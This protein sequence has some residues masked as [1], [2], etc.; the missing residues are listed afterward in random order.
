MRLAGKAAL[1]TGA[2]G[3]IGGAIVAL[4]R[5]EGAR[6]TGL[7]LAG[8]D[9]DC[10]VADRSAVDAA[11]AGLGPIDIVVH[12]AALLGGT[13]GFLDVA[14]ADWRRYLA[15][16]LEGAFHVCQAAARVMAEGGHGGAIVTIGSVNS[17]AAEPGAAAYVASKAG[18][19]GLTRAMAVDLA[20]FGI[21]ANMVAPGPIAVPRN[22]DLFASE[23]MQGTFRRLVPQRRAGTAAD[24][25]HAALFLAEDGAAYV[26]GTVLAVDGGT[27]AQILRPD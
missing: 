15:V 25:A 24:V 7:D 9:V 17:L 11:V 3:G 5:A 18:L 19:L 20:E 8:A 6:V 2:A 27:L 14:T 10:D 26:T 16:N 1:V 12:A 23:A 4:F 13:G 22:A 21:R